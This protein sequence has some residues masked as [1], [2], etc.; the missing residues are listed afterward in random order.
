MLEPLPVASPFN[1]PETPPPPTAPV[2]SK[3]K[4]DFKLV[5]EEL[6]SV[7][8]HF[9]AGDELT[10]DW[11]GEDTLVSSTLPKPLTQN[12]SDNE[13]PGNPM[14]LG[15][16]D[17]EPIFYNQQSY[18]QQ[19]SPDDDEEEND[20]QQVYNPEEQEEHDEV[21]SRLPTHQTPVF[22]SE[23][24]DVWSQGLRRLSGPEVVS[25]SDDEDN[26]VRHRSIDSPSF[27][28]SPHASPYME[29]PSFGFGSGSA[30]AGG[31]GYEEIGGSNENPWSIGHQHDYPRTQE[32]STTW[33][34]EKVSGH[35]IFWLQ[36]LTFIY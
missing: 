1:R 12:D 24:D 23:L 27:M 13:G 9:T 19:K 21:P 26:M 36:I 18:Q 31:G 29:S 4:K 32:E 11:F 3:K 35:I 28:P 5:S 14:V 34:T 15:D 30:D 7:V 16:E 25:E 17:V 2:K 33:T 22:K 10:D 8:D 20:N 6:P